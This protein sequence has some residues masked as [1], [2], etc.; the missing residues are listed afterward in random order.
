LRRKFAR[1]ILVGGLGQAREK[2]HAIGNTL[3][4]TTTFG[5]RGRKGTIFKIGCGGSGF[6]V[7]H[8]FAGGDKDGATPRSGLALGGQTL[9]GVTQQGGFDDLG[10]V[11]KIATDGTGFAVLH[12]F[13]GG[14]NDGDYPSGRLVLDGATL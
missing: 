14:S 10:T 12:T 2:Q 1:A 9:Y 13:T 5:G 4:G 11:Y 3:Y 6:R 8:V 7:L